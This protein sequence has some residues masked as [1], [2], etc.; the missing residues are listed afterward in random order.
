MKLWIVDEVALRTKEGRELMRGLNIHQI[1]IPDEILQ[2]FKTAYELWV[3]EK[4][5]KGEGIN[6]S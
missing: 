5:K 6:E 3:E 4:N 1:E 2:K